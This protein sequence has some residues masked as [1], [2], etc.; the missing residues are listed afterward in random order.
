MKKFAL[1]LSLVFVAALASASEKAVS[2]HAK[3]K[4]KVAGAHHDVI[5]AE[6]ISV[7]TAKNT[8]TLKTDK[9]EVTAPAEGKAIASLKTVKAGDKVTVTC[10]DEN[11]E[12]KA[13][14]FI[15]STRPATSTAK[16]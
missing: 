5:A 2:G 14:T 15:K 7:D 4:A 1:L 6:V 10:R 3:E 16:P 8:I 9:G 11:G 12:H 13:V